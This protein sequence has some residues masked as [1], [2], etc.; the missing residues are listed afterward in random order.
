MICYL[1]HANMSTNL[2]YSEHLRDV[3]SA[4]ALDNWLAKHISGI[5]P[6]PKVS[7]VRRLPPQDTIPDSSNSEYNVH[8]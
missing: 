7:P 6:C 3:Y 8:I 2:S 4:Y 5:I 1:M